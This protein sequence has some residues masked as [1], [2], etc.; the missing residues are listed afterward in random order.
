M[1]KKMAQ[2]L[3]I[4]ATT[5]P[6]KKVLGIRDFM[7]LWIGQATSMLG[8]QFHSIAASWLVLKMTGDPMALGMVMAISGIP[9]ALFTVIGGAVTD[10]ISPRKLMLI[11]DFVRL[12]L[13][14]LLAVQIFTGT[15]QVWMVYIY[16]AVTGIMGG[17]FGPASMSIVPHI[18]PEEDL[19]AGNSLTQGSSS[20][21]GFVG[22][23]IAG[24]MIAA[25]ANEATGMGIA[26]AVDALTFVVSVITLW[27]MHS[28]EIVKFAAEKEAAG[29]I[30]SS[31]K[32]GFAFMVKDPVLRMMFIMIALANLCF[33]GPLLVGIPFLAD[34]RFSGGA[35]AY[36][37]II[38]GYAGGNLLGIILSGV[39]PKPK[40]SMIRW[41][42]V[43]MFAIFG[44]GLAAMS[45]I[46]AT[47]LATANLFFLGILNG[48]ISIL[49]ITGLQR[50]T[51]KALLGRLM[52]MILLAN[53]SMMPISQALSGIALRWSVTAVFV[54]AGLI[55]FALTFV[56]AFSPSVS[57]M[58]ERLTGEIA[59]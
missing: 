28:G 57:E 23:A 25:F 41:L 50:G 59:Q 19:Q 54:T 56:M 6:M 12:F 37:I 5:N 39:L 31:V 51:P 9:R 33:T 3:A 44:I 32:E 40:K 4:P 11:T 35:A 27:M 7:L 38:S 30:I 16:A 18:V 21:I 43:V 15:L 26:I 24:A 34:T 48:Y 52:S 53:M 47:W 13:S 1:E 14:T 22:P 55:L 42:M 58:G 10:R 45:W 29:S 49:M 8:D 46:S 20:L 36:G 2:A 17:L